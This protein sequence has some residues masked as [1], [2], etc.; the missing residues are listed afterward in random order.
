MIIMY[1]KC[2][3]ENVVPTQTKQGVGK[4]M[5]EIVNGWRAVGGRV[6]KRGR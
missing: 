5:V 1:R 6:R 4:A 2:I 3:M